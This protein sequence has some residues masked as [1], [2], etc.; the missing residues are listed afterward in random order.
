MTTSSPGCSRA[1]PGLRVA[2]PAGPALRVMATTMPVRAAKNPIGRGW[3][4]SA[5][6]GPV[7]N[8]PMHAYY[9]DNGFLAR[10]YGAL[11]EIYR[12]T[13]HLSV[14]FDSYGSGAVGDTSGP[15]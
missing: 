13:W 6:G 15:R 5:R 9:E 4:P 2:E 3:N 8:I 10:C 14:V 7:R 12:K 11:M 1:R